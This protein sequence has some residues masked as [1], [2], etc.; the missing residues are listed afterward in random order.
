MAFFPQTGLT[1]AGLRH[2]G[3][4]PF[5]RDLHAC[6][7]RELTAGQRVRITV[8]VLGYDERRAHIILL[9][10]EADAEDL[11]A[12]CELAIL[13]VGLAGRRPAPWS[14]AQLPIWRALADAHA[15]V[16]RPAQAGRAVQVITRSV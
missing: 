10:R 5:L 6:Y 9:M 14:A 4:S 12:T 1:D 16:P 13:N 8:Q 15:T 2:A 3:T 11:V 7:L